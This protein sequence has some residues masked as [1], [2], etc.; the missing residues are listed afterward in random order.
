MV[1]Q[2]L[3][4][5]HVST[6]GEFVSTSHKCVPGMYGTDNLSTS[7]EYSSPRRIPTVI[8]EHSQHHASIVFD[9]FF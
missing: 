1:L 7:I 8:H 9:S 3:Q 4:A 2:S 5:L 6:D